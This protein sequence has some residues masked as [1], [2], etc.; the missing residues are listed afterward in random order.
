MNFEKKNKFFILLNFV[1]VFFN[2]IFFFCFVLLF[3][4]ILLYV[5]ISTIFINTRTEYAEKCTVI[6]FIFLYIMNHSNLY[7]S[8]TLYLFFI[9]FHF[10]LCCIFIYLF[11]FYI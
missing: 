3:Y 8:I 1:L 5:L 2:I 4:L 11:I 6:E 9:V 7:D 10:Y